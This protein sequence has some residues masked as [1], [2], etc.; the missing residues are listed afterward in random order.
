MK[1][2]KSVK[3]CAS[4]TSTRAAGNTFKDCRLSIANCRLFLTYQLVDLPMSAK[5]AIGNWKSAMTY[6]I[7]TS[8]AKVPQHT[9]RPDRRVSPAERRRGAFLLLWSNRLG[10]RSYR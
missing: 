1:A 8:H 7:L 2:F 3:A 5:S 10:L 4:G 9:H 6:L